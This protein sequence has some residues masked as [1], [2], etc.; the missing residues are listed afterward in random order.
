LLILVRG[1]ALRFLRPSRGQSDLLK[2]QLP[3]AAFWQLLRRQMAH[4]NID[5]LQRISINSVQQRTAL[6]L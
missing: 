1:M 4:V 3:V 2:L 6:R 5:H